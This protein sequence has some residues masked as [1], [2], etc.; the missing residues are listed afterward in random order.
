MNSVTQKNLH[1]RSVKTIEEAQMMREIRNSVREYM[2]R[3]TDEISPQRQYQWFYN[4]YGSGKYD[5]YLFYNARGCCVGYGMLTSTD[6]KMWGTLAVKKEFQNQGYG[7]AIYQFLIKTCAELDE[8]YND[9]FYKGQVYEYFSKLYKNLWIEIYADNAES[10]RAAQKAGFETVH[11]GDKVITLVH[12]G[13][14]VD[15]A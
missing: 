14:N 3:D 8:Q 2:T 5:A 13:R 15:E 11:V 7:T 6:G 12:R 10:L 4:K 1:A 9:H